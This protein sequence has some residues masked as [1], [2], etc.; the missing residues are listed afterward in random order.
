MNWIKEISTDKLVLGDIC[1]LAKRIVGTNSTSYLFH[2]R[3]LSG[4]LLWTQK[5]GLAVKASVDDKFLKLLAN[6]KSLVAVKIPAD[7]DKRWAKR[8]RK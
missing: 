8:K 4:K 2:G 3:D 5:P 7:A 6:D 1:F